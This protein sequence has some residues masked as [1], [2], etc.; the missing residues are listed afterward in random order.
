MVVIGLVFLLQANQK[1]RLDETY[2]QIA[3]NHAGQVTTGTLFE[4]P[5][6]HF[7]HH[8]ARVLLDSMVTGG[9]HKTYY[10][11]LHIDWPDP[12]LRMRVFPEGIFSQIGKFL[13]TQ[14]IQIGSAEFDRNYIIQGNDERRIADVL[15]PGAQIRI[16]ALRHFLGN[17]DIYVGTTAGTLLIKKRSY[18]RDV[19]KL[20]QFIALGLA[21]SDELTA[22]SADGIEFVA[23]PASSGADDSQVICQI[24]GE[25][26]GADKVLCKSCRTPHHEDCWQYYGACSTYGCGQTHYVHAGHASRRNRV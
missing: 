12:H 21:L 20:E 17:N 6:V 14:D 7:M 1:K 25:P 26:I 16:N 5:K 9:K 13:G 15:A 3:R 18:I 2:T 11:Q 19:E 4:R 24:C 8:G 23:A 22:V 10:T